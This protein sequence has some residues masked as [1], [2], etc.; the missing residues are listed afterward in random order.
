LAHAG[1]QGRDDFGD[2][3]SGMNRARRIVLVR[4]G[5]AEIGEHAVTHEFRDESVVARH[6]ARDRVLICADDVAHVLWV[7]PSRQRRRADEI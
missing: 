7:E 1:L 6:Y 3:E 4:A 5:E 2:F